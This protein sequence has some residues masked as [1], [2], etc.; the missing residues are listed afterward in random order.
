MNSLVSKKIG[1]LAFDLMKRL[2]NLNRSLTGEG[3]RETLKLIKKKLGKLKIL[4]FKCGKKVFDWVIPPEWN[5]KNAYVLDQNKKKIIDFKKNNLHL[6][7]YSK[8]VNK[9]ISLE[10]L[11]NHLYTYKNQPN[12]IPYVTSYYNRTWGFCLPFNQLKKLKKGEYTVKIDSNF[13]HNGSLTIGEYKIKG[14]SNKEILIS[15]N[16]CH[17]SMANNE[18]SGPVI[19]TFLINY[20][21]KKKNYYSM[22]FLFLPETIGPITYLSKYLKTIKKNFL[23]GYHLTCIGDGGDFSLIEAKEKYSYSTK[24]AKMILKNYSN[25]KVYSFLERGSDER[26]YNNPGINL[27]VATLMRTKFG[28]YKEYHSSLDNLS[29]IKPENLQDS[30]EY[31]LKILKLAQNDFKIY[32]TVKGEPFLSKRN[33]YRK[34]GVRKD[35]DKEESKLFNL[36]SYADGSS[37]ST[38]SE[39]I[40]VDPIDLIETVELLKKHKLVSTSY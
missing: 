9:K 19:A 36:M 4:E 16:I 30:Y 25:K 6:V 37:L 21:S 38:I 12:A 22:R 7:G 11:K 10:K 3:N 5:V 18:L 1:L 34:F 23:A 13:N 15:T 33:L 35:L 17:P 31:V 24:I 14:K 27:S 20:F 29:F 32:S 40:D 26:Q 28:L 2:F 39:K 8:A